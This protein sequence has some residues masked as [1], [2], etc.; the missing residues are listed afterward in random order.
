MGVALITGASSGLGL[1]FAK[2]F[3]KD[4]HS[5]I[6]VAR[7]KDLLEQEAARLRSEFPAIK[8]NIV[9]MDLG[10][11]GAGRQLFDKVNAQNLNIEFL[12]NNAGFGNTGSFS[13]QSLAKE[14]QL[15]DL[16]VRTL[17]ELTHL[18]L[19]GM[20]KAGAGKILNVG[21]VAGFQPGPMMSTYYASKA[22]VNSF[23]EGLHEELKGTGVTC[24]VLAPGATATEFAKASGVENARLFAS[25]SVASSMTVA[26]VG[27][28]AMMRGCAL[29]IPGFKNNMMV[30]SV[31]F[32]P[33]FLVRKIAAYVNKPAQ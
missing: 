19:P 33:R 9:D 18:F 21:S 10:V 12:V 27:Y 30:Q 14:M 6:L 24:T 23:S 20:I 25:G 5:L 4:G 11:P 32:S 22:F 29:A 17:V 3:A 26:E 16:N 15:I 31:R 13:Q 2:L 8:V 28:R 1:E 7:R